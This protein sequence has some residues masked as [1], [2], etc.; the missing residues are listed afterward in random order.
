MQWWTDI[1]WQVLGEG[2][3]P[4]EVLRQEGIHW[5]TL[6]SEWGHPGKTFPFVGGLPYSDA[7]FVQPFA[8]TSSV[9]ATGTGH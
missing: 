7:V 5:T 1:R 2:V 6:A 8:Q 9:R 3:S 4:R